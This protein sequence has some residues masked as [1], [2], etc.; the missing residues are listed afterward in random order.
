MSRSPD[1]SLEIRA[2]LPT[3]LRYVVEDG[4][5]PRE[6]VERV[7]QNG[8]DL[9]RGEREDLTQLVERVTVALLEQLAEEIP[10]AIEEREKA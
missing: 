1:L 10:D 9:D 4:L 8:R 3:A 6:A 7:E 5:T 2:K